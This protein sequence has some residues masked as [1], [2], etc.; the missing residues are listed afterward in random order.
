MRHQTLGREVQIS[1]I[2]LHSG[3]V[4]RA[5]LCPA[6]RVGIIFART[7]LPGA[8]QIPAGT[9][10]VTTTT[11]ATTLAH[12]GASVSTTE[13]LMATLWAMGITACRI[14]LDG[15]EVP[16]LDG[17]AAPWVTLLREAGTQVLI[18]AGMRPIYRL[19]EPVWIGEGEMSVLGVPHPTFRLTCGVEYAVP[20]GA[21]QV[22]D[23]E[24]T[25]ELFAEELAPARTFTLESWLEPLRSQGLIKGGSLENALVLNEDGPSAPFRFRDELAR[26]K[27]LDVV[28]DAALL[29]GTDGGILRAHVF[30]MR[31]GHGP[32]RVWMEECLRRGAL[33]RE[34]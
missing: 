17:S 34:T 25:P 2:G 12:Q 3:E 29:F 33:R 31:A 16:I 32:H 24:V 23:V 1:G 19:I 5:R 11:H 14:E 10:Y 6:A 18:D 8:P 20:C 22:C 7:D 15:P 28:G 26:H 21:K 27:A 13:H 30:A 9:D 4:V